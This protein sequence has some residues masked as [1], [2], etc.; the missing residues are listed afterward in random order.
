MTLGITTLKIKIRHSVKMI[1]R[2]TTLSITIKRLARV[3]HSSVL[4]KFKN[5]RQKSFIC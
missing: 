1:L 4:P 2:I 3:K 5:Y